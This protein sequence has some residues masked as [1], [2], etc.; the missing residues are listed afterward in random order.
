M[1]IKRRNGGKLR[2]LDGLM[3]R[4]FGFAHHSPLTTLTW[5]TWLDF[6]RHSP[7]F[8]LHSSPFALHSSHGVNCQKSFNASPS[9]EYPVPMKP[10]LPIVKPT[11]SDLPGPGQLACCVQNKNFRDCIAKYQD[12]P[13]FRSYPNP[14]YTLPLITNAFATSS[15]NTW[16]IIQCRPIAC[17]RV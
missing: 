12:E 2:R 15:C 11:R 16:K 10:L 8:A 3:V 5:L 7:L 9:F 1:Q 4:W 6:A 13:F 17:R 14:A